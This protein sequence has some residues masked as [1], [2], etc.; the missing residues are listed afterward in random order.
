M[1]RQAPAGATIANRIATNIVG[2]LW[3][4]VGDRPCQVF[5]SDMKLCVAE[6]V[7]YYPD[8][9]IVCD[10]DDRDELVAARPCL[11]VEVLSPSTA[12]IDLREKA[13]AYRRLPSLEA[14]IVAYQDEWRVVRY[15][16]DEHGAWRQAEI[17]GEG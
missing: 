17:V 10:P 16:R 3:T 2:L 11:V 9:M 1:R 12:L 13:L 7:I 6:D 4:A 14:Y 8:V 15:W 5:Q